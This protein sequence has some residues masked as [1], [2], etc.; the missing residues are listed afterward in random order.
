M[1]RRD[2][3]GE[4]TRYGARGEQRRSRLR[5]SYDWDDELRR[6]K[7]APQHTS[8]LRGE[9]DPVAVM[10][11]L[12]P[13]AWRTNS[14]QQVHTERKW[15][16]E[17]VSQSRRASSSSSGMNTSYDHREVASRSTS[18]SL[19]TLE[20]SGPQGTRALSSRLSC[21]WVVA[22]AVRMRTPTHGGFSCRRVR[23]PIPDTLVRCAKTA[24]IS[25]STK[26]LH[27]P[28]ENAP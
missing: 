27:G 1:K 24:T 20:P 21:R 23:T 18:A 3:T 25:F 9:T 15:C 14:R 13:E 8:V 28:G 2:Y 11:H 26:Y 4:T 17:A 6:K 22:Y 5:T 19:S 16:Q 10:V 7:P 12:A